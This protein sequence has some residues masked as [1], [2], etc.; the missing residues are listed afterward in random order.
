MLIPFSVF[1]ISITVLFNYFLFYILC[2][3]A[4]VLTKFKQSSLKAVSIFMIIILK[5]YQV[6]CLS[7]L[8]ICS[9]YQFFDWGFAL[10]FH[11]EH[12]LVFSFLFLCIR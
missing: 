9:I 12:I 4:E 10:F 1:F 11:L 8:F 5:V 7:V 2:F 6:D 3:F